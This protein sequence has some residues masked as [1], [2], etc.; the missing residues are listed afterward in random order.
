MPA[1]DPYAAKLGTRIRAARLYLGLSQIEFARRVGVQ[2]AGTVSDWERGIRH[3]QPA[4]R[5]RVMRILAKAEADQLE[6]NDG[7]AV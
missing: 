2:T 3:P 4:P 1:I 7:A 6:V 5:A